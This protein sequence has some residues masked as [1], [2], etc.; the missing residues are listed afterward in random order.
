MSPSYNIDSSSSAIDNKDFST[1]NNSSVT[2]VM[3][4]Q[5]DSSRSSSSSSSHNNCYTDGTNDNEMSSS[6][7]DKA[8]SISVFAADELT[9]SITQT[10][11]SYN[12]CT[13]N[14]IVS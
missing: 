5:V 10:I 4:T 3:T 1:G 8:T 9:S 13:R 6:I 14:I 11:T 12:T 2:V 7:A